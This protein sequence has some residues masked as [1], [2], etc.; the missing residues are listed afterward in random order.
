M[1]GLFVEM[2]DSPTFCLGWPQISIL[3]ISTSQVA[4]VTGV[5]N[6]PSSPCTCLLFL[7]IYI[8]GGI[9]FELRA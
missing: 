2:G 6:Q 7:F 4:G 5:H 3:L 8:F 9:E 1:S